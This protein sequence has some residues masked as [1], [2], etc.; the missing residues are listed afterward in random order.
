MSKSVGIGIIGTGF[1]KRVQIPGFRECENARIVSIASKSAENARIAAGTFGIEHHTADWRETI[2][3]RDVDL[4]CITTPPNLHCEMALF[5]IE[6][7]KHILCEKPMAMNIAEAERMANGAENKGILALIDFELRFQKG[8]RAAYS[9]LHDGAIGKVRHARYDFRAPYR[10]TPDIPW[11]WWSDA[12]QGGGTLGA[13]NSHVIDSFIWFLGVEPAEVYCQLQSHIQQRRDANGEMRAV[14]SDDQANMLMRFGNGGLTANTTCLVSV[15]MVEG[16]G[17]A[18]HLI[19]T[20]EKG[21]LRVDFRDDVYLAKS[22][23]EDWTRV[24]TETGSPIGDFADTGFS[25]GFR[26]FAPAIIEA[27]RSGETSIEHAATFADGVKVQRVL[28]AARESSADKKAV[29][30]SWNK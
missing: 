1:A 8:R 16:P 20:G 21:S 6:N 12:K 9:L 7:G 17:F 4:V 2:L 25:R 15:S 29:K 23:E 5:A 27:I 11:N 24:E 30:L 13:I 28:D 3:H 14:T 18:N 19:F 22:G 10:G 26:E